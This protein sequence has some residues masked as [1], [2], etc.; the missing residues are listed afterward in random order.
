MCIRDSLST[1]A[2]GIEKILA[3][4]SRLKTLLKKELK[5]DLDEY[6]DERNSNI[7]EAEEAK[8]FDEKDLISNDPMTVVL[9]KRGWIRAAKGHEIDPESLQ[10][11]EGDDYLSS[12]AARNSQNAVIIDSFGKAFTLPIH[13]LPSARGQGDP[14]SSSINSQSGSTF[15]GVV[16]GTEEELSLIHI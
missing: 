3:S 6:G 14:V 9:S 1:E 10:Y 16:A 13:K 15:A 8:A 4:S 5:E 12:I 2:K 11:R 7:V